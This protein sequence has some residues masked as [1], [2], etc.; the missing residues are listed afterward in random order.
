MHRSLP[1]ELYYRPNCRILRVFVGGVRFCMHVHFARCD[2]LR[3]VLPARVVRYATSELRRTAA[4][5]IIYVVLLVEPYVPKLRC[6]DVVLR[7]RTYGL[8]LSVFPVCETF[9]ERMPRIRHCN[10]F[11]GYIYIYVSCSTVDP[12]LLFFSLSLCFSPSATISH[13]H[14]RKMFGPGPRDHRLASSS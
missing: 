8:S 14:C 6:Y 4:W 12:V 1:S 2:S 11:N 9:C 10:E 5:V 7:T 13:P 3:G